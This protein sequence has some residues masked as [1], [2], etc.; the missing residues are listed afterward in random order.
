MALA[1]INKKVSSWLR[2]ETRSRNEERDEKHSRWLEEV[3]VLDMDWTDS[4]IDMN[5]KEK[6]RTFFCAQQWLREW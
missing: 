4:V 6:A 2:N 1:A 5:I 3:I